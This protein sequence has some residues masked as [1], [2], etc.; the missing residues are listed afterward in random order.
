MVNPQDHTGSSTGILPLYWQVVVRPHRRK[1]I[2]ISALMLFGAFLEMA[3]VGIAVPLLDAV[4]SPERA[5]SGAA[6]QFVRDTLPYLRIPVRTNTVALAILVSACALFLM[7]SGF[8]VMHQY[9]TAATAQR[10]RRQVK[11][12]LFQR[13]L[14]ARYDHLT[15]KDR[16]AI[17]YDLNKPADQVHGSIIQL[18]IIV[19]GL[20]DSVLLLG[21]MFYLS[22]WA[23]LVVAFLAVGCV[24]GLRRFLDLRARECGQ[25]VYELN[26]NREKLE[27]DAIDGLKVVKAHGLEGTLV[28]QQQALL[29]KELKPA[30]RLVLCEHGPYFINEIVASIMVLGLAAVTF[31][32]PAVGM[33]FSTMVGFLVAIRR[34]SPSMGRV[35]SVLVDLNK[36]SRG[37]E[38]VREVL[39]HLPQEQ[40]GQDAISSIHEIK[41]DKVSFYYQ[42][43]PD[44]LVLENMNLVMKRGEVTAIVGPTGAGKTTIVNLLMGLFKPSEG[45]ILVD[46]SDLKEINVG[47][48]REKIGYVGQDIFLFNTSIRDNILLWEENVL[49]AEVE[50]AARMAQLHDFVQSLPH[51]YDTVVGDRGLRLSGGQCQR[52]AI[53]RAI[54]RKPEVLIF[55]EATS[56]LDNLTENVVYRAINALRKEATVVVI[57]H[58]LSTIRDADQIAVLSG[59]K[60]AEL[61]THASL[62][63]RGGIYAELYEEGARED[64]PLVLN[65]Q[66]SAT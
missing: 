45:R 56:A 17:L 65:P 50:R 7:R 44:E 18:G 42:A 37:V 29:T 13:F 11:G 27:V 23:T 36:S 28:R 51:G 55:D 2:F 24:Q 3:T 54:I 52:V 46:G 5:A 41:L 61:G 6:V 64:V 59:G 43:R 20:F 63:E 30:L 8:S 10:L 16:G 19:A 39:H 25:V 48:W 34:I 26:R 49:Q 38:V 60:V 21:L 32:F 4:M 1:F 33:R 66:E 12:E 47:A 35:N 40:G 53:A 31:L 57:A 15:A 9:M 14:S 22:W 58:R 62:V